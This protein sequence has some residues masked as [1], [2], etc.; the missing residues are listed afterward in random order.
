MLPALFALICLAALPLQGRVYSDDEEK[1]EGVDEIHELTD[2]ETAE[3]QLR[4]KDKEF[5]RIM[6]EEEKRE[7]ELRA[8]LAGEEAVVAELHKRTRDLLGKYALAPETERETIKKA[9]EDCREEIRQHLTAK[10]TD[11]KR[12]NTLLNF[13]ETSKGL[14][15]AGN[16]RCKMAV[17]DVN[18]DGFLDI[19]AAVRLGEL[20]YGLDVW[21][22]DGKGGWVHSK[23]GLHEGGAGGSCEFVDVNGDKK[24]D[25]VFM[26]HGGF[27][28]FIFLGDG[29][30]GWQEKKDAVEAPPPM[31]QPKT[32][33]NRPRDFGGFEDCAVGDINGDGNTDII[34]FRYG[35]AGCD[36]FFGD[37]T[38]KFKLY[39]A[40]GIPKNNGANRCMLVDLNNDGCLDILRSTMG[41][42][43]IGDEGLS[44]VFLGDGAGRFRPVTLG[45]AGRVP[46]NGAVWGLT[47]GDIN[48]DGNTDIIF[49]GYIAV[50]GWRAGSSV[51]VFLGN[52]TGIW[53]EHTTGLLPG[54][55]FEPALADFDNDGNMDLVTAC[56][57]E[58]GVTVYRGDGKG[59]WSLQKDIGMGNKIIKGWSAKTADID[60]DGFADIVAALGYIPWGGVPALGGGGPPPEN[61][62]R[63]GVKCWLNRPH[64]ARL[65]RVL[66]QLIA[67]IDKALS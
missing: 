39:H 1:E 42:S 25:L 27:K 12:L 3:K 43:S 5:D 6:N 20:P 34:T 48:N 33:G 26:A 32:A 67:D 8:L 31:P 16:W 55:S 30:G 14:P 65:V 40:E 61:L 60:G 24:L 11:L 10:E 63:G 38:G 62:G 22:Y 51:G 54:N 23:K 9:L 52:G 46:S 7:E 57:G 49:C 28:P 17:G 35:I 45:L 44:H 37:G 64:G 18:G 15:D 41:F 47:A 2:M 58:N 21:L 36:V 66:D 13:E 53:R 29:M 19:T 4:K 56:I 50:F 59:T